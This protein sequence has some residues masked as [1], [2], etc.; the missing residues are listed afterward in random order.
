[1]PRNAEV[2]GSFRVGD[3][4]GALRRSRKIPEEQFEQFLVDCGLAQFST[5]EVPDEEE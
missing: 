1:M 3:V 4:I 2:M 5:L